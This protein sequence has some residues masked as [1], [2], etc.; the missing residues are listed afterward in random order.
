MFKKVFEFI[1]SIYNLILNNKITE[2]NGISQI[3]V[4]IITR[5]RINQII[6]DKS[7]DKDTIERLNE[8]LSLLDEIKK[9]YQ[10]K[11][12][13]K[14]LHPDISSKDLTKDFL[15]NLEFILTHIKNNKYDDV[16]KILAS[17]NVVDLLETRLELL[18]ISFLGKQNSNYF[19]ET[20]LRYVALSELKEEL[21]MVNPIK[22]RAINN[23]LFSLY[24]KLII[25]TS[26]NFAISVDSKIYFMK[27]NQI[28]SDLKEINS[29]EL[30]L[31]N[32]RKQLVLKLSEYYIKDKLN[33]ISNINIEDIGLVV[34]LE[35]ELEKYF[36][37]NK[38]D[39]KILL[40]EL[41]K[42]KKKEFNKQNKD[43]LLKEIEK[44]ELEFI[45][46]YKFNNNITNKMLYDLY[47]TKFNI[48]TSNLSKLEELSIS[49][50]DFGYTFYRSIVYKKIY[51]IIDGKNPN[52]NKSFINLEDA[53]EVFKKEFEDVDKVL[54]DKYRLITLLSFDKED[55]F[56][57]MLFNRSI[58]KTDIETI[59][60]FWPN[61][62]IKKY[63]KYFL[64]EDG[65]ITF[66]NYIPIATI[67]EMLRINYYN[68]LENNTALSF[69]YELYDKGMVKKDGSTY[70]IPR[71]ITRI[72]FENISNKYKNIFLSNYRI[73]IPNSLTQI[74]GLPKVKCIEFE[75]GINEID[76]RL[77]IKI[78]ERG[79]ISIIIPSS[80]NS[81][82]NLPEDEF[83][84]VKR[85]F[86]GVSYIQR[87]SNRTDYLSLVNITFKNFTNSSFLNNKINIIQLLETFT[88][89][90]DKERLLLKTFN[91]LLEKN[92]VITNIE[93][94]GD[95]SFTNLY[96]FGELWN[97]ESYIEEQI[98]EAI[99]N[100]INPEKRKILKK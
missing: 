90:F 66:T 11:L 15:E 73:I 98:K 8:K 40:Q 22:K 51:A 10:E 89:R 91:I 82:S 92:G 59:K 35:I 72:D 17:G 13:T 53:K 96:P 2:D 85:P 100:E 41:S 5:D 26:N 54:S 34:Y 56:Y 99:Q 12:K 31:L 87:Y 95:I 68:K 60:L 28:L 88:Y 6:N 23:E 32:K 84:L 93:V 65:P 75:K 44:L 14:L 30:E 77:F 74:E 61:E 1:Y 42:I 38:K 45:L 64:D 57:D 16:N 55:L 81:F 4:D 33:I 80:A 47:E 9:E 67:L 78:V 71:G 52:F 27:I 50:E 3:K 63:N 48:L 43:S 21:F 58:D 19:D 69:I 25:C 49:K 94:E 62:I 79:N 83:E 36:I 39:Y 86:N 46:N 97:K 24:N 7:T 76:Y 18:K 70:K 20:M 29:K 37:N